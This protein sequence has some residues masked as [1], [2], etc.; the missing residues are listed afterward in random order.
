[1]R[2]HLPIISRRRLEAPAAAAAAAALPSQI[3]AGVEGV[4]GRGG[5]VGGAGAKGEGEGVRDT[6]RYTG[7]GVLARGWGER[8]A[9]VHLQCTLGQQRAGYT[10]YQLPHGTISVLLS[11]YVLVL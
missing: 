5:V 8:G 6:V 9:S 2:P 4:R 7:Y 3:D 10:C 11:D 1:M